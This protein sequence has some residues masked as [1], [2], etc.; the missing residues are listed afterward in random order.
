MEKITGERCIE[1]LKENF[2]KFSPYWENY[3]REWGPDEGLIIQLF[4]FGDYAIDMIKSNN[5]VEIKK[6]FEFV[7]FLLSNGDDD[8]QTAITTGFLEH[9]M[10]K[11]PHEIKFKTFC[12]YL[13]KESLEYCRAWDKFTGVRTEGLWD[14]EEK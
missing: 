13:G 9:L 1:L 2:P 10:H 4:P 3:I 14:S 5:E 6:I 12:Q 7:E 11:D 8:V